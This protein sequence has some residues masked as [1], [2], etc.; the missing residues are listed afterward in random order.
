VKDLIRYVSEE[1]INSNPDSF[2][3]QG[4][5]IFADTSEDL[6]GCGNCAYVDVDI[7]IF[8]GYHT[9][10]LRAKVQKSNQ[11]FA[12]LFKS[13]IYCQISNFYLDIIKKISEDSP[14]REGRDNQN[15]NN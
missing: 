9:I 5:F 2:A 14:V 10:I 13:D 7:P 4:D 15:D 1:Y 3:H 12:Y 11:Y 8:A 6:D